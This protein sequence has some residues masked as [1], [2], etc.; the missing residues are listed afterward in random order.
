MAERWIRRSAALRLHRTV[1]PASFA[2]N[3]CWSTK[4]SDCYANHPGFR[5]QTTG[6]R[7]IASSAYA[8]APFIPLFLG[9]LLVVHPEIVLGSGDPRK[10]LRLLAAADHGRCL[11]FAA[12]RL[13]PVSRRPA[14]EAA[15][16]DLK[17]ITL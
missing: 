14:L 2:A 12:V 17:S 1:L 5:A 6:R 8:Q 7:A 16:H 4:P 10:L 13:F 15:V 11:S 9:A 3:C